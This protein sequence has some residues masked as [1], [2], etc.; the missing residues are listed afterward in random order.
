MHRSKFQYSTKRLHEATRQ[1]RPPSHTH[2]YTHGSSVL[3]MS[4]DTLDNVE[5]RMS[6][7]DTEPKRWCRV[8]SSFHSVLYATRGVRRCDCLA[9]LRF[10]PAI[11][12][13]LPLLR[14]Q[15]RREVEAG[16]Q[17]LPAR[18]TEHQLGGERVHP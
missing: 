12:P 10:L 1:T 8:W 14:V 9:S 18:G 17:R 11:R 13:R 16:Q 7:R 4:V 15:G 2:A 5:R 6:S 3:D